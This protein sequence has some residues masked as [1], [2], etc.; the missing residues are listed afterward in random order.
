MT[1]PN[2][3]ID[4]RVVKRFIQKGL[5]DKAEFEKQI[6]ALPDMEENSMPALSEDTDPAEE[7]EAA[8]AAAETDETEASDA[9]DAE[10]APALME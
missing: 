2:N 7:A 1:Y 10:A 4:K 8:E 6:E 3:L 9:P 5:V